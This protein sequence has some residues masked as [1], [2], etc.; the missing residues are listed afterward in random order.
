PILL[1][2]LQVLNA[3]C[4]A[5]IGGVGLTLFQQLIRRPRL[6]T[7]LYMDTR[8]VGAILSGPLIVLGG[9]TVLGQPPSFL[10][11]ALLLLVGLLII[12]V[13]GGRSSQSVATEPPST[14]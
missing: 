12:A 7:G 3:W 2:V 10:A 13:A 6:S 5:G 14:R 4:F 1:I 9:A 8:R 11:C